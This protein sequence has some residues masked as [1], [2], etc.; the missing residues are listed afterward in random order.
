MNAGNRDSC[1]QLFKNLKIL[2][3]RSQYI[4]SFHYLLPKNGDS[5][6]SNSAV[7]NINT[8][9]S[10]ALYTATANFPKGPFYFGIK[11]QSPSY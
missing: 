9:F 10:S 11:F 3:L 1:H 5:Y 8:I 6:E 4:F 7:H 2:L